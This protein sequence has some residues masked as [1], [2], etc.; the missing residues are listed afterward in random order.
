VHTGNIHF[1]TNTSVEEAQANAYLKFANSWLQRAQIL[2]FDQV[3]AAKRFLQNPKFQV[4]LSQQEVKSYDLELS[5]EKLL[6][7]SKSNLWALSLDEL[8]FVRDFYRNEKRN[9]TDVEMEIIAQTWSE[10]C[11]H[12][13]FAAHIEHEDEEGKRTIKSLFKTYIK[14][15]TSRI[16]E[17][18]N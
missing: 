3:T 7:L 13:I 8:H 9:P 10:H 12:K 14:G 1:E 6:E 4:V 2:S 15:A 17:E 11:K 18:R 5:D 16:V